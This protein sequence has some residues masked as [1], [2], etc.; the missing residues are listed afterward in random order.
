MSAL[1]KEQLESQKAE[2]TAAA[3]STRQR[4][5]ELSRE[6]AKLQQQLIALDGAIQGCDVL[7]QKLEVVV[8]EV[9]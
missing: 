2:W 8:P 4:L 5:E 1:S 3:D 7:L 6:G 9:V